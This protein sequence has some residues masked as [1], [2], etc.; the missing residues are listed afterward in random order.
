M[1]QKN[2]GI[3]CT[4]WPIFQNETLPLLSACVLLL[5][6][7]IYFDICCIYGETAWLKSLDIFGSRSNVFVRIRL[8]LF[9]MLLF[10]KVMKRPCWVIVPW[11]NIYKFE[12]LCQKSA[13]EFLFLEQCVFIGVYFSADL[14]V[15]CNTIRRGLPGLC[16]QMSTTTT[17]QEHKF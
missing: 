6:V 5:T 12:V 9:I 10:W 8:S 17:C 16:L 14:G 11:K 3:D 2:W 4:I 15:Y 1:V 7:N 13:C